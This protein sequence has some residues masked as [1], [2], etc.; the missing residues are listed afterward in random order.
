MNQSSTRTVLE[1]INKALVLCNK[2]NTGEATKIVRQLP[3]PLVE[4]REVK[5]Q[6]GQLCMA[7][8]NFSNAKL[9]FEELITQFP[10]TPDYLYYLG[11]ISRELGQLEEAEEHL[12]RC[13]DLEE[14]NWKSLASM[15]AICLSMQKFEDGL[16]Y[17]EKAQKLKPGSGGIATNLASCLMQ[18]G[19]H[20][21][22]LEHAE[23]A[24]KI[25][26]GNI[27]A[28]NTLGYALSELGR[29]EEAEKYFQKALNQ[30]RHFAPALLNYSRIK[31]YGKSDLAKIRKTEAILK[32]SMSSEYRRTVHFAIGKMYDDCGEWDSAF[33]HFRQANT[34][35]KSVYQEKPLPGKLLKTEKKYFARKGLGELGRVLGQETAQPV[36]VV[37]M[38]RSGTT[39]VEQIIANHPGA[40]AAGELGKIGQ[41][42][43]EI[44][45]FDD[46]REFESR[47]DS[48][49]Q[50]QIFQLF[51]EEYL[52]Q[53]R[54][55]REAASRIVDKM[56]ENFHYLGLIHILFP[57]SRIVHIRRNP[58]D[59]CLSCY[60]HSFTS[61][62]W[63]YDM[64][65]IAARY[66]HY[67]KTLELWKSLLPEACLL[68]VEYEQ[69]VSEPENQSRRMIEHIGLE[70]DPA[71]L[72]FHKADGAVQTASV[73]Q[74]R[75]PVYSSSV[76]RWCHY[77][78]NI[79]PLAKQLA[80]VLDETD[81][82][83]LAEMGIKLGKKSWW[84]GS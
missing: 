15:G 49:L 16:N 59:T 46:Y 75:Q 45:P 40:H 79:A 19:R 68:E 17:L 1:Q 44:C 29:V 83:K 10:Q 24:I 47:W 84:P 72:D 21:E 13:L 71:C 66:L 33:K 14:D 51:A 38:P 61:I 69:L 55:G 77:G 30:D 5:T 82:N 36:F 18:M 54:H 7:L 31:K 23:K 63:S 9:V 35:G 52:Q 32:D 70:W 12:Q 27:H 53:L 22:S 67:L 60:F 28:L 57:N 42:N 43:D 2:G 6:F 8:R 11:E 64:G 4:D 3:S 76:R 81:R 74:V 73:W 80:S 56:P 37:G 20:E 41:I 58:L 39:L 65:W 34:L 78:E 50:A 48:K 26:P 25:D 62:A